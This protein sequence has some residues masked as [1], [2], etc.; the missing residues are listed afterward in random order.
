MFRLRR[1]CTRGA[2]TVQL[3]PIALP[4]PALFATGQRPCQ[5]AR[6]WRQVPSRIRALTRPSARSKAAHD[7]VVF[8]WPCGYTSRP[9]GSRLTLRSP[10]QRRT[11]SESCFRRR[12][13]GISCR[14]TQPWL[15]RRRRWQT[16]P[17]PDRLSGG[18][19]S[20]HR[21]KQPVMRRSRRRALKLE[22]ITTIIGSRRAGHFPRDPFFGPLSQRKGCQS[23][24]LPGASRPQ[25]K[26][27]IFERFR[28]LTP[29]LSC[30]ACVLTVVEELEKGA[31]SALCLEQE[32]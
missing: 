29:F 24:L 30:G 32:T 28:A 2:E 31:V 14:H 3:S 16:R 18:L 15:R 21:Q 27:R 23:M 1:A 19:R 6:D 11:G 12:T 7:G 8:R 9:S 5:R 13:S 20:F 10:V 4:N 17:A 26:P 22:T 25:G